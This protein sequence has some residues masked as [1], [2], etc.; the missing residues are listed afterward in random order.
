MPFFQLVYILVFIR[1]S[2][3]SKIFLLESNLILLMIRDDLDK[4]LDFK[5][6]VLNFNEYKGCNQ[7]YISCKGFNYNFLD[8]TKDIYLIRFNLLNNME[9]N[10]NNYNFLLDYTFSIKF[11][12][13]SS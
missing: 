12:M 5:I 7:N 4:L 2:T 3:L 10:L 11:I 9:N 1:E 13:Q 6:S 8:Y